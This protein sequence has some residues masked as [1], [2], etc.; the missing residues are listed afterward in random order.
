MA[1]VS[2]GGKVDFVEKEMLR[3]NFGLESAPFLHFE[4]LAGCSSV[5]AGRISRL[6]GPLCETFNV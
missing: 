5:L 4:G 3:L 6:E 2:R 1:D